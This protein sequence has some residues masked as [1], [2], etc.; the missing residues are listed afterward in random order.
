[1]EFLTILLF[2]VL[3]YLVIGGAL[4]NLDYQYGSRLYMWWYAMTHKEPL[5]ET[6]RR[7]F[8][9]GRK[10]RQRF[11]VAL[12]SSLVIV[13][14]LG[15]FMTSNILFAALI[16][17]SGIPALM[18]GFYFGPPILRLWN[19]KNVMLDTLDD[20][21]SGEKAV[22]TVLRGAAQT[23]KERVV[24]QGVSQPA[25]QVAAPEPTPPEPVQPQ[26]D[27]RAALDR[28]TGRKSS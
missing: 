5:V 25:Q 28:F 17:I 19:K 7:G 16:W 13:L 18:A 21:E 12:L 11:T 6:D 1:M 4:Y 10:S 15:R 22:G 23:V 14:A 20:I 9:H 27:P 2:W 24:G 3:V 8:I 26:E